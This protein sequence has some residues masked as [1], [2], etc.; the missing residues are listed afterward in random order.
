MMEPAVCGEPT[1]P[2]APPPLLAQLRAWLAAWLTDERTARELV[3]Y[4]RVGHYTLALTR[5]VAIIGQLFTVLFVHF[6]IGIALPLV[7]LLA[8]IAASALVNLVLLW[9][10]GWRARLSERA[11]AGMFVFDL[12]Q[13]A[14]LLGLTGGIQN[15]FVVLLLVPVGIAAGLLG[16]TFT[17]TVTALG[18]LVA[19][20][21]AA[22]P[23][24]LPWFTGGLVFPE[25]YRFA[26]W[27]ALS[28]A[29][30][31]IAVYTYQFAEEA[32]HRA[33]ALAATRLALAREQELA[34]L[35]GQAAAAAHM[36]GSPL[37]TI[38]VVAKELVNALP[39]DHPLREEANEILDQVHRCREILK[40]LGPRRAGSEVDRLVRAPLSATLRDIADEFGRAG[41]STEVR[42]DSPDGT[43]EPCLALPPDIRHAI[44]NLVD[45][46]IQFATSR[47]D[48]LVSSSHE[49]LLVAIRDDGPGFSPDILDWIGEPYL[50]TRHDRGGLGLGI[51]IANTLLARTGGKLHFG[52]TGRGAEVRIEW[53]AGA[54]ERAVEEREHDG[55]H[56]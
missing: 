43:P 56:D 36:L 29:I 28:T 12:A 54:L 26:A 17:A 23:L 32:R 3:D 20:L 11:A 48:I 2:A 25:L 51:F 52:N 33:E 46:A 45:N 41:I 27:A 15:P 55:G 35:G 47:V 39:A 9:V 50:S 16:R 37:G 1:E 10:L 31:L 18:L 4:G 13:L 8:A 42:V 19:S 49:R 40:T 30:L 22:D 7:P 44:A 6:S 5:W 38:A 34:A 21:L 24:P 14:L 53:P